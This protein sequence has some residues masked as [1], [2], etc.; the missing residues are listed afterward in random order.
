M[1]HF[2]SA[3]QVS[4]ELGEHVDQSAVQLGISLGNQ[5]LNAFKDNTTIEARYMIERIC[6]WKDERINEFGLPLPTRKFVRYFKISSTFLWTCLAVC[7]FSFSCYFLT[8]VKM[9]QKVLFDQ[10]ASI[11]I[12]QSY[13]PQWESLPTLVSSFAIV[14]I[15]YNFHWKLVTFLHDG[16]LRCICLL[17]ES[18]ETIILSLGVGRYFAC[19]TDSLK[20]PRNFFWQVGLCIGIKTA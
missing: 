9:F 4:T 1:S 7:L 19:H 10:M 11:V 2:D 14:F 17:T 20:G 12:H 13:V 18:Y 5:M 3:Y 16:S 6:E 15:H 8:L